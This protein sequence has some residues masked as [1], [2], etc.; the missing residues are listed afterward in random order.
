MVAMK[1]NKVHLS[2]GASILLV[3]IVLNIVLFVKTRAQ[4]TEYVALSTKTRDKIEELEDA[5]DAKT[6]ENENLSDLLATAQSQN[7]QFASDLKDINKQVNTLEK[8][9]KTDKELLQKYS[10]VFFLNEHYVPAR[11]SDI[12]EEFLFDPNKPQQI[13]AQVRKYVREMIRDA[14]DDGIELRI[15]S[16]Y[17]SFDQQS[18]LKASYKVVYGSG[19]N[20]FSADQGYSEHQLGTAIDFEV[21]GGSGD[22]TNFEKTS[23][24]TWLTEHAQNYGFVL[25]YPKGNAY[26]QFEPWHWRFVGKE[27]ALDLHDRGENFYDM[28]QRE[29]DTYLVHIFD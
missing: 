14:E 12:D 9:S 28:D 23:A 16:A 24:Y 3:S 5:I 25:S 19:A 7:Q 13:H 10:K 22:F 15:V 27:L 4:Q 6:S 2:I 17:R 11:L 1:L 20:Q 8:L 21:A 18:S 29:I 26:Y